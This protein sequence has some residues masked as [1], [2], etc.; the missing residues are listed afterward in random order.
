MSMSLAVALGEK[1]FAPGALEPGVAGDGVFCASNMKFFKSHIHLSRVQEEVTRS[2]I[3]I[4]IFV[5]PWVHLDLKMMCS[6]GSIMIA[7]FYVIFY[8]WLL[9][10]R[11]CYSLRFETKV[12]VCKFSCNPVIC[13]GSLWSFTE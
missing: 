8:L 4:N 1:C 3:L 10:S 6:S 9:I 7:G 12:V 5:G 11:Q 13:H 2:L